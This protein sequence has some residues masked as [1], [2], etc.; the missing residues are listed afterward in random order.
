MSFEFLAFNFSITNKNNS[1]VHT[2]PQIRAMQ[3][4]FGYNTT[5]VT[6]KHPTCIDSN[7]ERLFQNYW[8]H[9][10]IRHSIDL[11]GIN[12]LK[13]DFVPLLAFTFL[14]HVFWCIV[15]S[16]ANSWILRCTDKPRTSS[17]RCSHSQVRGCNQSATGL[18]TL[19]KLCL[20]LLL[21]PA[22]PE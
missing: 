8:L 13:V 2:P 3:V 1:M 16:E 5:A 4:F 14:P 12:I 6:H 19:V 11:N 21:K 18:N 9:R 17:H 20:F 15:M 7:P 22:I 10:F